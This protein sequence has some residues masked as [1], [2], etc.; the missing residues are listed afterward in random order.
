MFRHMALSIGASLQG[1]KKLE[2]CRSNCRAVKKQTTKQSLF[3]E[4][5]ISKPLLLG[6][7]LVV[8]SLLLPL[9]AANLQIS[10]IQSNDNSYF[11]QTN[12]S[13]SRELGDAFQVTV[14]NADTVDTHHQKLQASDI[15][16]TLGIDA[17]LEIA[18]KYDTKSIVSAYLTLNQRQRHQ[19]KLEHHSVVLLDQPLSRYL[20]FTA[21]MLQPRS[22]G[23]IGSK[24]LTLNKKQQDTL[25]EFDFK[26]D[27]YEFQKQTNLLTTVRQLL[28]NNN[29]FLLLPD[30]NI[31]NNN[32]LKGILLTSYRSRKPIISYSPSHV[33]AGALASIFSSP[34]DIGLQ[35]ASVIRQLIVKRQLTKP[36]IQFAEY[37]SV[38]VNS[39]VAR[40]LG[41]NLPNEKKITDRLNELSQ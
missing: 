13:L 5:P 23:I 1:C 22:V 14:I 21:L 12:Q 7:L 37:F 9:A 35:L 17:A 27:Q 41:I 28:K 39:R 38:E 2:H 10:V 30:D 24:K 8:P 32:T 16:I 11:E 33:K 15:I 18:R 3:L 29:A 19:T 36:I 31:Y 26:L 40:A 6:L 25:S 20:A 34:P 4:V